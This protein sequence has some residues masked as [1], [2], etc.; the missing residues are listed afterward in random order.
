M[1]KTALWYTAYYDMVPEP[2]GEVVTTVILQEHWRTEEN[3]QPGRIGCQ[4]HE[5]NQIDK[6]G[7]ESF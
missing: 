7:I 6:N 1:H 2:F 4:L 3:L 5:N